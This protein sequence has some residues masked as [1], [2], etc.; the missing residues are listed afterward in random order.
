MHVIPSREVTSEKSE[1]SNCEPRSVVT[2]EGTPKLETQREINVKAIDS[3]VI[4]VS[5]IAS[6]TRG[7]TRKTIN[8]G[9]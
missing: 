7:G 5:G 1:D 8:N 6:G 4:S 3:A 2:V 9:Q